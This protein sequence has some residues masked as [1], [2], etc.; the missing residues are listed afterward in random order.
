MGKYTT[1]TLVSVYPF[2]RQSEDTEII[3]GRQDTSVFLVLPFDAVELLDY[4]IDGKTVGEAQSLYQEKYSEKPDL[5]ELLEF[6]E[7][8]G[9]VYPLLNDRADNSDILNGT[10]QVSHSFSKQASIGFH[11]ANFPQS[12]AQR[13]FSQKVLS[14]S[15][16]II[17]LALITLAIEPAIIPRWDAIFFDENLTLM[18]LVLLVMGWIAIF[19][20][21]MAHLIAVR[22]FNISCRLGV[23][24]RMWHLVAE[25]DMTGIWALPRKQR[26]LP[27]LAGPLLDA[28]SSSVLILILFAQSRGWLLLHP[29]VIRFG[30][31]LLLLYLLQ[32]LWQ[33]YFFVRTD[34]YYV[35]ANYFRCKSLM[36]DTEVF[37]RNQFS[38]FIRLIAYRDQSHIPVT[39]K[40]V[41]RTYAI[42]WLIGRIA[43]I[44]SLVLITV[45]LTW[46]YYL[47]VS[48]IIS[49]GYKTNP[50]AFID[51]LLMLFLVFA[52]QILGFWLWIR[53]F[54]FSQR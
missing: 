20:H 52:P 39:E 37:L 32:L 50:Y 33:C 30:R 26:Y 18:R 40:R 31:A 27:F 25:T 21:E 4:L 34:F 49:A 3:I 36:K 8:K 24:N 29:V 42:I 7:S 19:L 11:F 13:I 12:L 53:S 9:F 38:K 44:G 16:I 48:R 5:E 35:F 46:N 51:A 15:G 54:K 6:L 2:T 47:V 45:P 10:S 28:V 41:I 23:S 17:C 14:S 43:A 22:A 1:E